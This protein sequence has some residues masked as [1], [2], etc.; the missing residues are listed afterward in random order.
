MEALTD[1]LFDTLKA[2][3]F[4]LGA[5]LL[6]E[7]LAHRAGERPKSRLKR[8]GRL[9]SLGGA[10]F[11]LVPQCGFSVAAANFYADR[12]ITPG[13][14]LAVFLSTSDEA[15]PMLMSPGGAR[16]IAPLIAAKVAIAVSAGLFADFALAGLWRPVWERDS[17]LRH[18][19]LGGHVHRHDDGSEDSDD[20]HCHHNHCDDGIFMTALKRTL[21]VSALI[22]CI[23]LAL[24]FALDFLG[25]ERTASL[26]L[27]G[28]PLQPVAAALFGLVPSCAVSVF[29][30]DLNMQGAITFGSMVAG[31]STGAGMGTLVLAQA[32]RNRREAALL[33]AVLFMVGAAAGLAIDAL[34]IWR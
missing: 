9:G 12:V 3:P 27:R 29:L 16:W 1:A 33:L 22:F 23:T 28:S 11:G 2:M 14:L 32:C 13:T 6:L 31:L 19:H 30:A 34:G 5:C 21:R 10:I 24:G 25:E 18:R 8:F 7:W 20:D 4:L 17:E 15:I 26:L